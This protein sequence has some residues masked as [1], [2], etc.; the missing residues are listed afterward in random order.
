MGTGEFNAG[1]NPIIDKYSIQGSSD[2][3]SY[4]MLLKVKISVSLMG[5]LACMQTS[6]FI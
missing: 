5:P 1:G 4:F 6:P 3:P 2:T